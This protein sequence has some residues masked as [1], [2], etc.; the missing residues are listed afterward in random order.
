ML[1]LSLYSSDGVTS[2]T[3][4]LL[5]VVQTSLTPCITGLRNVSG[6]FLIIGFVTPLTTVLP[7]ASTLSSNF[8]PA[9][10]T[11]CIPFKRGRIALLAV[12]LKKPFVANAGMLVGT[13]PT[14][15]NSGYTLFTAPL[16]IALPV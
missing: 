12:L 14:S 16:A 4:L 5:S 8:L 13:L 11:V 15:I 6:N 10:F 7:K 9:L 2:L 1:L 3:V